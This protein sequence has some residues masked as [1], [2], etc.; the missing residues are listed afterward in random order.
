MCVQ[1]E[2]DAFVR[3]REALVRKYRNVHKRPAVHA[4]Y[5]RLF[6][7]RTSVWQHDQVMAQ[8]DSLTPQALEGELNV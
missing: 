4:E 2:E 7:L 1:V 5:L 6:A 8:L 3:V